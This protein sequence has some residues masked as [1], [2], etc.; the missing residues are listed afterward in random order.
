LNVVGESKHGH[1]VGELAS[2]SNFV[3]GSLGGVPIEEHRLKSSFERMHVGIGVE[4]FGRRDHR[5]VVAQS[6]CGTY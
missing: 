5:V 1:V 2:P 4:R 6:S 3:D